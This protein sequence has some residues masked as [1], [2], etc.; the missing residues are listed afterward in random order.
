VLAELNDASLAPAP[1]ITEEDSLLARREM[2]ADAE[3]MPRPGRA[4]GRGAGGARPSA[5]AAKSA[6]PP[7]PRVDNRMA[8]V[9]RQL[10]ATRD[11][12]VVEGFASP[13]DPDQDSASLARANTAREQLIRNGV[14]A[15]RVVAV[16]KGLQSGRDGGVRLVQRPMPAPHSPAA[17]AAGAATQDPIG[18]AHFESE[19]AMTVERGSSAMVSILKSEAAGEVVYLYDPESSRGNE[20]F[21]FK[22]VRLV[23]PTDS[24]LESGPVTVFGAGRFI[25]EGL[26]EPI[27]ARSPAFVPFALDRQVVVERKNDERDEIAR[28]IT[29][30]RGV[31]STEARHIRRS[32]F[33]LT[34]RHDEKATVYVRH[35]VQPGYKLTKSPARSERMGTAHLFRLELEPKGKAELLIEETT[36]VL[37]STDIRA[38]DGM[39]LVR[40]YLSSAAVS[41]ALKEQVG[42]LLRLQKETANLEQQITTTREQMQEYRARMDEL[43]AQI[44][45]LTE[46][47]SGAGLLKDLQRKMQDISQKVS[48]ATI[49][50]VN[51]QEKLMVSRINFQDA[52]AELSLEDKSEA[53]AEAAPAAPAARTGAPAPAARTGAP[54]PAAR[55]GALVPTAARGK[56]R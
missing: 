25:G 4:R 27:P 21:P 35:T 33:T 20:A 6:P 11:Q 7:P 3:A 26:V 14:P 50:V 48:Q 18:T 29:V 2:A 24:V 39:D 49:A 9:A 8:Q 12:I 52:V 56:S 34:N 32:A 38:S 53:A 30:Q 28:I 46:V 55:T 42:R 44:V 16:G 31:F 40:A 10:Q 41:G 22:A 15:D 54:A 47:K 51:L 17:P 36:P 37:K 19:A 43:H 5:P 13:S 1:A 45:T 23:N